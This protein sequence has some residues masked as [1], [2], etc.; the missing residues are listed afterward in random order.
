MDLNEQLGI[1]A[2]KEKK[3]IEFQFQNKEGKQTRIKAELDIDPW[4]L[5]D[6]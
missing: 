2:E 4:N 1:V 5:E 3:I 6:E